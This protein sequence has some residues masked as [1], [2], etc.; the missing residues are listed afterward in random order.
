MAYYSNKQMTDSGGGKKTTFNYSAP[1]KMSTTKTAAR[2]TTP[3]KANANTQTRYEQ[4]QLAAAQEIAA[5]A[6]QR[7]LAAQAAIDA[8]KREA[9][10][11][12][13]IARLQAEAAARAAAEAEAKRRKIERDNWE[14][15]ANPTAV[16][17]PK[18]NYKPSKFYVSGPLQDPRAMNAAK[19]PAASPLAQAKTKLPK[20][21]QVP[22]AVAPGAAGKFW[23]ALKDSVKEMRQTNPS[24]S[25][26]IGDRDE[27]YNPYA[28]GLN[29]QDPWDVKPKQ[30]LGE[31]FNSTMEGL[32]DKVDSSV[33]KSKFVPGTKQANKYWQDPSLIVGSPEF[34]AM[35]ANEAMPNSAYGMPRN[36]YKYWNEAKGDQL[37]F[38]KYPD[39]EAAAAQAEQYFQMYKHNFEREQAAAQKDIDLLQSI[40][41]PAMSAGGMIPSVEKLPLMSNVT[42]NRAVNAPNFDPT[43]ATG[44]RLIQEQL[45]NPTPSYAKTWL[46]MKTDIAAGK[47]A[48]GDITN[49]EKLLTTIK[50]QGPSEFTA[51]LSKYRVNTLEDYYK[52]VWNQ[53][54]PNTSLGPNTRMVGGTDP[55]TGEY[56]ILPIEYF[57][58]D[59]SMWD[60]GLIDKAFGGGHTVM[61]GNMYG[62]EDTALSNPRRPLAKDANDPFL[63]YY[64]NP[65]IE[66]SW[67]INTAAPAEEAVPVSGGEGG[68]GSDYGSG[69]GAGGSYW[70]PAGYYENQYAK[71]RYGYFQNLAKWVI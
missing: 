57:L 30:N 23:T 15:W 66:R 10:R 54:D 34:Y 49:Q 50:N 55:N 4:Q 42:L 13:E 41:N 25:K 32:E 45:G 14:N 51:D 61:N 38:S 9:A 19:M 65:K 36:P 21:Y 59:R 62:G 1:K 28:G 43:T 37:D 67:A 71:D 47:K 5:A 31:W 20:D 69:Y 24:S 60:Q 3:A 46:D 16:E 64:V 35:Q 48:V 12:A 53:D 18:D 58:G 6:E 27:N 8:Q 11:Q 56:M 17:E 40:N 63:D 33:F 52:Y 26:Y 29:S 68:Y 7:R 70:S 44:Q 2:P 39:P 22:G